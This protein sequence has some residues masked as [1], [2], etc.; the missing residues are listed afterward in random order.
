MYWPNDGED[1]ESLQ[2]DILESIEAA[3]LGGIPYIISSSAPVPASDSPSQNPPHAKAKKQYVKIATF[4]CTQE[5]PSD[6]DAQPIIFELTNL[7]LQLADPVEAEDSSKSMSARESVA[8]A[9]ANG[10]GVAAPPATKVG[11]GR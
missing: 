8:Q 10:R 7:G 5:Y 2:E 6:E 1:E 3:A 4:L 9:V 11:Y